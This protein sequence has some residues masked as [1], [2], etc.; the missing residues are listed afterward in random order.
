MDGEG[1]TAIMVFH[2]MKMPILK[3]FH[4]FFKLAAKKAM[5][6]TELGAKVGV[7]QKKV[8][9]FKRKI[10]VVMK[11]NSSDKL[12]RNVDIDERS[13]GGYMKKHRGRS[14]EQKQRC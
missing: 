1:V 12:N 5:S 10:Q 13:L 7:Q 11:Q 3:V 2:G 4:F 14:L 9:L 6:T 8:W